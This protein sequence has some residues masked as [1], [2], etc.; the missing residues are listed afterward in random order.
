MQYQKL[1]NIIIK[2]IMIKIGSLTTKILLISFDQFFKFTSY[3]R[4]LQMNFF[5]ICGISINDFVLL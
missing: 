2:I 5:Y 1:K 4:K 3:H